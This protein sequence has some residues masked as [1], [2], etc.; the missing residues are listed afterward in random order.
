MR[1]TRP[2]SRPQSNMTTFTGFT[3]FTSQFPDANGSALTV[4]VAINREEAG[5]GGSEV[6][7]PASKQNR[8]KGLSEGE[9]GEFMSGNVVV[10]DDDDGMGTCDFGSGV[11]FDGEKEV[12]DDL[13]RRVGEGE[14]D[15]CTVVSRRIW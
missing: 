1:T 15:G 12:E 10:D 5:E 6:E 8:S 3:N 14:D 2:H 4:A 7:S 9:V 11:A 13:E